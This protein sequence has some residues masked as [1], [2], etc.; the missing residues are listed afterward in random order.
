MTKI[1]LFG[2]LLIAASFAYCDST[3]VKL[4]LPVSPSTGNTQIILGSGFA[5]LSIVSIAATIYL[6]QDWKKP[7]V[8]WCGTGKAMDETMMMA[9]AFYCVAFAVTGTIF[10]KKGLNKRKIYLEWQLGESPK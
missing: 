3:Q 9:S 2:L 6:Y 5:V 7:Q 8:G 4:T 10:I 1:K